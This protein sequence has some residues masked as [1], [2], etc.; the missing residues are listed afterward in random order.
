RHVGPG[1]RRLSAAVATHRVGVSR[2]RLRAEALGTS[3]GFVA[4]QYPHRPAFGRRAT[5]FREEGQRCHCALQKYAAL[6]KS[7]TSERQER[8]RSAATTRGSD[9]RNSKS[10]S[11]AAQAAAEGPL[12]GRRDSA[13]RPCAAE[14][15]CLGDPPRAPWRARE[16]HAG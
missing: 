2:V 3:T 6:A 9:E 5:I 16:G 7:R 15:V 4:L 13:A 14:D 12:R 11:P 10:D 1:R 8:N